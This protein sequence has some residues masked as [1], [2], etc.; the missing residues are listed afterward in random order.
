MNS[1]ELC[2]RIQRTA[3]LITWVPLLE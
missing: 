3:F 1:L 2:V